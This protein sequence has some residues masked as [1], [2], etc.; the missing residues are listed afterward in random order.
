M[1]KRIVVGL[2][3]SAYCQAATKAACERAK[4]YDGTVI[5]VAVIDLPGIERAEGGS[6]VG[7][8]HHAK[9]ARDYHLVKSREQSV[10]L[11]EQFAKIAK[12]VGVAYEVV[13]RTGKPAEVLKEE[14]FSADLLMIG[15]RTFFSYETRDD[16]GDTLE[17]LLH[18]RVC[19][20]LAI[21]EHLA[22][23]LGVIFPYDG[24][25]A[26]ARAMRM[27][28]YQTGLLPMAKDIVLLNINDE[29]DVAGALL[30]KPAKY[31]RAYG[32]EVRTVVEVGAPKNAVLKFVKENAPA[33]VVLGASTKGRLSELVFGGVTHSLLDDGTIPLFVST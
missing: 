2:D 7:A 15:T 16:P 31:L 17:V 11:Q 3:P 30:E 24:S 14:S 20:V 22:S 6:G 13:E 21:P 26:A 12:K 8:A 28:N 33:I 19:P 23:P 1:S 4:F 32:H 18:A 25:V 10:V 5:G 29:P 9:Q 27:F